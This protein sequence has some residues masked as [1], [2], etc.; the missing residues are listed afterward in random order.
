[1]LEISYDDPPRLE[2]RVQHS[3]HLCDFVWETEVRM[4]H[5]KIHDRSGDN[6]KTGDYY[7]ITVAFDKGEGSLIKGIYSNK[8]IFIEWGDYSPGVFIDKWTIVIPGGATN[9]RDNRDTYFPKK[10]NL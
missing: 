7:K 10:T 2:R 9:L 5:V 6:Y 1:M 3:T 8:G 4:D